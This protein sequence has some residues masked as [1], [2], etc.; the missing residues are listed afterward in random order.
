MGLL[1]VLGWDGFRIKSTSSMLPPVHPIGIE[2]QVR[3]LQTAILHSYVLVLGYLNRSAII[4]HTTCLPLDCC[5]YLFVRVIGFKT[6][7]LLM[8][9]IDHGLVYSFDI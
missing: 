6:I 8:G 5:M 3:S 4:P 1:H 9:R 2:S 7:G